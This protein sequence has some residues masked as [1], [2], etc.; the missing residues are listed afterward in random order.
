MK[1]ISCLRYPLFIVVTCLFLTGCLFR[2]PT[3]STRHFVLTPIQE[4]DSPPAGAGTRHLSIE[5]GLVRMPSQLLRDSVGVR[6]GAN[7][8][9]YLENAL[10]AD[11]LDHSF[12]RTL[13]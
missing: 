9:E 8:I 6:N 3:D 5:I 4:K 2:R 1:S 13:A 10:W 11:R 12:E 7:E